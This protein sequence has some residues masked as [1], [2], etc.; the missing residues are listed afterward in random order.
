[1]KINENI[2]D[3]FDGN[4]VPVVYQTN[5]FS[6]DRGYFMETYSKNEMKGIP[7]TVNWVQDNMSYSKHK[8]TL[9]GIHFQYTPYQQAKLVRVIKGQVLDIAVDLRI[10][11]KTFGKHYSIVLDD[12]LGKSFYIPAGFGHAFMTLENDTIFAYKCSNYYEPKYDGGIIWN[13]NNLSIDW[14]LVPY[15]SDKDK[16]LLTLDEYKNKMYE[17]S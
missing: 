16:N 14:P 6:D 13:D 9:R 8:G 2:K 4:N 11:S 17:L 3:L 1:M 5:I 15:L 12:C 10:Q 7:S